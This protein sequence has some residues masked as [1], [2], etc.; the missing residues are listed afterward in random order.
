MAIRRRK[1]E[2]AWGD[3]RNKRPPA[4]AKTTSAAGGAA[5]AA[6]DKARGGRA[7]SKKEGSPSDGAS[8]KSKVAVPVPKLAYPYDLGRLSVTGDSIPV[9]LWGKSGG[10][11]LSARTAMAAI[12]QGRITIDVPTVDSPEISLDFNFRNLQDASIQ[13]HIASFR[14]D[15]FY[16][17]VESIIIPDTTTVEG[18]LAGWFLSRN[19][20]ETSEFFSQVSFQDRKGNHWIYRGPHSPEDTATFDMQYYYKT[21]PGFFFP[22]LGAELSTPTIVPY[23]RGYDGN[24]IAIG[25]PDSS[26]EQALPITYRAVWPKD[27]PTLFLGESLT[28]PKRGLPAVRGQSSLD[29]LYQQ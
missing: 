9:V 17:H 16:D 22:N 23:L 2:N 3:K 21:Q 6:A 24:G 20:A 25:A 5:A 15:P 18:L 19:P 29:I 27:A 26:A 12:S 8:T 4:K 14:F 11:L 1:D 7:G 10:G 13:L 28:T